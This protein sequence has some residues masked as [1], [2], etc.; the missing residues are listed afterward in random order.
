M[1]S[2]VLLVLYI[3]AMDIVIAK[4]PLGIMRRANLKKK[5]LIFEILVKIDF[6]AILIFTNIFKMAFKQVKNHESSIIFACV[7]S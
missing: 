5:I 1:F 7:D 4:I 2:C 3:H 6:F